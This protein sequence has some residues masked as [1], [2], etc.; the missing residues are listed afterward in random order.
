MVK[1]TQQEL[2]TLAVALPS[3]SSSERVNAAYAI[4]RAASQKLKELNETD[5]EKHYRER[6]QLMD[7]DDESDPISLSEFLRSLMD[8]KSIVVRNQQWKK[9]LMHRFRNDKEVVEEVMRRNEA[10]GID[11]VENQKQAFL[12]WTKANTK[13]SNINRAKKGG[14]AK[15]L[16]KNEK[17]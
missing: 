5:E 8:R 14:Y 9:F 7:Y 17:K 1:P 4:W 6:D 15:S 2:A 3:G 12:A 10:D 13:Q 16:K 11:N